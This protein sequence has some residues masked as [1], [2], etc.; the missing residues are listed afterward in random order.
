MSKI[1]DI[2]N[3]E[4][5]VNLLTE[6]VNFL[7]I[8][9]TTEID[10]KRK[11]YS[12]FADYLDEKLS[13]KILELN[14]IYGDLK[15]SINHISY[16]ANNLRFLFDECRR[17][18]H[19]KIEDLK[20]L[21]EMENDGSFNDLLIRQ[22]NNKFTSSSDS[23]LYRNLYNTQSSNLLHDW[24]QSFIEESSKKLPIDWY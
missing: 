2:I 17:E 10:S 23:T 6:V 9:S 22:I 21:N 24:L 14:G 12:N 5:K 13:Q 8:T 3:K 19:R 1:N 4:I 7:T 18:I 11:S 16:F 20:V 15:S